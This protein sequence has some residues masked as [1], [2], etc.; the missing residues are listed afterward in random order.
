MF[1]NEN[2]ACRTAITKE[3]F[4]K[5]NKFNLRF[6]KLYFKVMLVVQTTVIKEVQCEE[7]GVAQRPA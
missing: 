5:T 2:L 6:S 1:Q 7:G 4:L 3:N